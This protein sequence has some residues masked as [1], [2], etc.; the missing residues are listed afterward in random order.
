M[1]SI[2]GLAY[3]SFLIF[4]RPNNVTAYAAGDVVGPAT[5][6]SGAVL[7]FPQIGPDEAEEIMVTTSRLEYDAASVPAGMT[8]FRLHFY[9]ATPPSALGD[10]GLWDLTAADRPFY[11]GYLDLGAPALFGASTLYVQ[12]TFQ[13][14]QFRMPGVVG[15]GLFAYLVTNGGFTPAANTTVRCDLHSIHVGD[16]H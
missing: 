2:K 10:G 11:A 14:N 4:N 9:R 7:Q 5:G 3:N 12:T 15:K 16:S 1:S 13:N 8:S 6:A